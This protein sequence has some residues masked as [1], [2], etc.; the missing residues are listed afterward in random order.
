[1]IIEGIKDD[2]ICVNKPRKLII[3]DCDGVLVDSEMIAN[4]IEAEKLTNFGYPISAQECIERFTGM[5]SKLVR[6][7]IE[8]AG[9]VLPDDL[10]ES[11]AEE[12][13]KALES[14]VTPL[15]ADVL[16]DTLI[17]DMDKCVASSSPKGRV[18]M[19]LDVTGQKAFF[20]E[21]NVFTIAQVQHGKPAPD[22]FLFAAKQMGYAPEDCVVIEDSVPGI[23][24]AL[25]ANMSVIAFLGGSHGRYNVY[26]ERIK[27]QNVPI[28]YNPI[29]LLTL[30]K[31]FIK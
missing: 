15:M 27:S 24:A 7:L 10:F 14:E 31:D 9:V 17:K 21:K 16:S 20:E 26:E 22:L 13:F 2:L 19:S 6:K 8:D 25:A 18:L 1:M 12:I 28:A 3:F 5:N 11:I 30:M 4:R 29:D 23:W